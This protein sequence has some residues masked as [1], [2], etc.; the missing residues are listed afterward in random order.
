MNLLRLSHNG[1]CVILIYLRQLTIA[2][3]NV[4]SVEFVDCVCMECYYAS[5]V[6]TV[7]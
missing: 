5:I 7:E 4:P 3:A 1:Y 2:E 6:T